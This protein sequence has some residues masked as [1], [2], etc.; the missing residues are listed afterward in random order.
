MTAWVASVAQN[1][2]ASAIAGSGVWLWGRRHLR[3]LH[4]RIDG[5]HDHLDE[6]TDAP[7]DTGAHGLTETLP[8]VQP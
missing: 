6:I 8:A 7:T 1:L 4:A 2:I 5:L 3:H